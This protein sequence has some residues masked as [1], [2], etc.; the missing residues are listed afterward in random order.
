MERYDCVWEALCATPEEAREMR[1]R[2][3][4]MVHLDRFLSPLSDARVQ[5]L[6]DVS[7]DRVQALRCGKLQQFSLAEL[8]VLAARTGVSLIEIDGEPAAIQRHP[9]DGMYHGVFIALAGRPDFYAIERD[10]IE[11]G[12][13][14]SLRAYGV[15]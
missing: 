13:R 8:T 5:Q 1:A 15:A 12:G 2:S 4:L 10:D 3:N 14:L 7:E 9:E 11:R 6:L